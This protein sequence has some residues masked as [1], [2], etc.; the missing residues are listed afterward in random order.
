MNYQLNG[1]CLDPCEAVVWKRLAVMGG[2]TLS[3]LVRAD[4]LEEDI[5][6]LSVGSLLSKGLIQRH[7][8]G[9]YTV[10]LPITQPVTQ[11]TNRRRAA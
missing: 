11:P 9:R 10:I 5:V 3:E 6:Q 2:A 4:L 8:T 1:Q 7:D